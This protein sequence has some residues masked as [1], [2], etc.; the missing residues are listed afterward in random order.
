METKRERKNRLQKIARL[1]L[2]KTGIPL[3]RPPKSPATKYFITSNCII[4]NG[5]GCW[6]WTRN[7]DGCGYG[8]LRHFGK[9]ER[10]H[11]VSWMLWKGEIPIGSLVL[12]RCDNP[13]CCNPD[14]LFLG[15]N[16]DNRRDCA[17]KERDYHKLNILQ[18]T[19]IL[20]T[21]GTL[22]KV[23]EMFGVSEVVIHRIRKGKHTRC[24]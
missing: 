15:S 12:H 10:V 1:R 19:Q 17:K 11:R 4:E 2:I 24:T 14:H 5:S 9:L 13:P 23:G 8:K 22:K 20:K 16:L 18:V 3:T 7:R 6:S 21:P